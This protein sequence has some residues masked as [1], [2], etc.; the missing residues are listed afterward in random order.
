MEFFNKTKEELLGL[1]NSTG[2]GIC[3][4]D[5]Q[6]NLTFCNQVAMKMFGFTFFDELKGHTMQELIQPS[7]KN[8]NPIPI[9]DCKIFQ[10]LTAGTEKYLGMT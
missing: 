1:L 2:I 8:G 4:I 9:N 5:M 3:E 10:T 7:D 6:G